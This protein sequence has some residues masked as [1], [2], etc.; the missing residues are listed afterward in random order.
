ME[1]LAATP[2]IPPEVRQLV[3]ETSRKLDLTNLLLTAVGIIAALVGILLAVAAVAGVAA[4]KAYVEKWAEVVAE[5]VH[6][7]P[8]A[9]VLNSLALLEWQRIRNFGTTKDDVVFLAKRALEVLESAD[10]PDADLLA[11]V[12]NNLAYYYVDFN[13]K[14]QA[15]VALRY[16]KENLDRFP[17][18]RGEEDRRRALEWLETYA[19]VNSRLLTCD[20]IKS[21]KLKE[22]IQHWMERHEP[23]K[24]LLQEHL[25]FIDKKCPGLT[26]QGTSDKAKH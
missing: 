3:E 13:L 9:R 11:A 8:I 4:A 22:T 23:I 14:E 15:E 26:A 21:S 17:K 20:E 12:K 10:Q 18:V 5:R 25:A 19:F 6:S 24:A 1:L 7:A 2:T 16:V